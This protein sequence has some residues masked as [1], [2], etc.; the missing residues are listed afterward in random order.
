[1]SQLQYLFDNVIIIKE[2]TIIT[3]IIIIHPNFFSEI[4]FS[5]KFEEWLHR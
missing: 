2:I 1:M 4:S 5:G 3:A